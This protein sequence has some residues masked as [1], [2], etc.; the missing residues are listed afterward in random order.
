M[1]LQE[2]TAYPEAGPT[3]ARRKNRDRDYS[4]EYKHESSQK[5]K[6]YTAQGNQECSVGGNATL[7]PV[8]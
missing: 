7:C 6:Q 3:A 8:F 1:V 2:V 5:R 4:F